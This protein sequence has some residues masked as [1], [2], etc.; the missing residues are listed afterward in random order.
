MGIWWNCEKDVCEKSG[1]RVV[2]IV[3]M[4]CVWWVGESCWSLK[5]MC[6]MCRGELVELWRRWMCVWCG[7][8]LVELCRRYMCKTW[9][10]LGWFVKRMF[11]WF[12]RRFGRIVKTLCVYCVV[13]I[14]WNFENVCVMY[15]GDSVELWRKCV[16]DVWWIIGGILKM[17]CVCDVWWIVSGIVKK[18]CE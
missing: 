13:E 18:I 4:T 12:V 1:G 16:C 5:T 14:W 11:M 6:V 9:G 3:K 15:G 17:M 2:G 8:Y 7:A 10:R